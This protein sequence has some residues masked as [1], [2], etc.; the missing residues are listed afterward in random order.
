MT[1]T[2]RTGRAL[3]LLVT[4]VRLALA[5][6]VLRSPVTGEAPC[7][8]SV[9][10][11]GRRKKTVHLMLE[12]VARGS[13]RP[14]RLV[15]VLDEADAKVP[16]P[17][18]LRRL[19]A[20]GLEVRFAEAALGPHK[21]WSWWSSPD[22]AG[23]PVLVTADDDVL[24]PGWWLATLRE[25]TQGFTTEDVACYRA[26]RVRL[27]DGRLTGYRTWPGCT[28]DT[29]SVLNFSTG[30][31][32]VAYP[33]SFQQV[34]RDAGDGYRQTCP[35]ADDVWLHACAVTHGYE[36]R[37]VLATTRAF[38]HIVASQR[39]S[40]AASNVDEGQNDVQIRATYGAEAL[41]ALMVAQASAP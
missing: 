36:V 14:G 6:H 4:T 38:H 31:S 25:A 7:V 33:L 37:Q 35:R 41:R 27:E 2:G 9:A 16:L 20:R 3:S 11:Y 39:G 22:S 40:L 15:L 29:A 34:L 28:T 18:P 10:S 8:V 5:N 19:R 13:L 26:K 21:K 23:A 24:Y 32:G 12:S 30:N 1:T 17:R